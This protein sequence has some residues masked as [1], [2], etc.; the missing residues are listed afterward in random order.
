MS[1]ER[2][3]FVKESDIQNAREGTV[4]PNTKRHT[5]WSRNCYDTWLQARNCAF[6]DFEP[7]DC[8]FR[9]VP[10]Q[11]ELSIDEMNYWLSRFVLE[12]KKKDGGDYRHEV[13]YSLFCGLNRV[14]KEKYPAISVLLA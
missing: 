14:I 10:K 11:E 2:F 7:E 4:P 8:R 6:T 13:L 12:V 1:K 3:T 9:S 5:M